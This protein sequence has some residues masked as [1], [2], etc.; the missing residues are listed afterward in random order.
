MKTISYILSLFFVVFAIQSLVAKPLNNMSKMEWNID[1]G[2][3]DFS[4]FNL[5]RADPKL[6]QNRCANSPKCKAWTYVRPHT[7]QG[8]NPRCWLKN[9]TPVARKNSCCISGRK[10][11]KPQTKIEWNTDRS[12]S[13]FSNFNLMRADPKLCQHRCNNDSKC[14]AWTYVR[15]HTTQ[16]K[17][18]RCW[19]KHSVPVARKNACC[20]SGIK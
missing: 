16:G 20:V 9:A 10:I 8:S 18:P 12:G 7:T 17:N 19:L 14:K 5:I 13:D 2:G 11:P 1:R 6:C 3:A 15:P 4:N